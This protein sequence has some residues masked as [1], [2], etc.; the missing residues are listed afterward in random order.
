MKNIIKVFVLSLALVSA[1]GYGAT[2]KGFGLGLC[3]SWTKYENDGGS[4]KKANRSWVLGYMSGVNETDFVNKDI[5]KM[6][7]K[8]ALFGWIDNYCIEN[9]QKNIA[10]ATKALVYELNK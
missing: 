10:Q 9:P 7:N 6:R 1:S 4:M 5:L 3:E 2:I 8:R